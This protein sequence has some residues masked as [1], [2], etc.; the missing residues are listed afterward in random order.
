MQ[1]VVFTPIGRI[2]SPF[3]TTVGMPIQSVGAKG[4]AGTVEIEPAY[5]AGLKDIDGFDYLILIYY[6]HLP[7]EY[8]LEVKPFLDE[9][10]H[11]VFATRSPRRPNPIGLSIV[12]L[13][14]VAAYQLHIEDVDVIDGTPLLDI[15]PYVPAF[16]D[17][18]AER[19]GW[20]AK[21]ISAVYHVSADDRFG[22]GSPSSF[23]S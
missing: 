11:G 20:L 9:Q 1:Q 10:A 2:R 13:V 12:R 8:T 18:V 3:H 21:N 4:V 19:I 14:Q 23:R 5:Q 16:D 22:I 17:R 6:L 15:K 7:G